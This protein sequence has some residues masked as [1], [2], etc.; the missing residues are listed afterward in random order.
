MPGKL[1]RL[2]LLAILAFAAVALLDAQEADG[3]IKIESEWDGYSPSIYDRG[4]QT[5]SIT[6]GTM[7]PLFYVRSDGEK[8]ENKSKLGGA[9]SLSYSYF[10]T[11][12]FAL[13]GEFGG[14]F[15]ATIGGNMLFVM[16][17]GLRATYQ[18]LYRD[19][20]FPFSLMVGGAT[21]SYLGTNYLGLIV[22][23]GTGAYWRATPDW[24]FGLNAIWWWMPEWTDSRDT[25]VYGNFLELT[26]SARDHF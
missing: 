26:L 8:V 19:F 13:G 24:S 14:M 16:P 12:N 15:S 10:F 21:Q 2:T 23:P 18:L 20:E 6:I 25:T 7:N 4:D 11:P 1:P 17:F 22:K 5:F 9:G 3:E